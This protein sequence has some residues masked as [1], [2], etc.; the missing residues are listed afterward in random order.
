MEILQP[1]PGI[2]GFISLPKHW[3]VERTDGWLMFH[4]RLT[5]GHETL[6][7][8]SEAMIHLGV[9]DMVAR[10]LTGEAPSPGAIR[11][12]QTKRSFQGEPSGGSDPSVQVVAAQ[13]AGPAVGVGDQPLERSAQRG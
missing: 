12:P 7:A 10:R 4:R 3:T 8:R 1:T 2:R 6:P 9:T 11:Y 13:R 5:R